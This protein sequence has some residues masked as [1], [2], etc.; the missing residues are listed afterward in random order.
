MNCPKC[1]YQNPEDATF[2]GKC[3]LEFNKATNYEFTARKP[4]L[5]KIKADPISIIYILLGFFVPILGWILWFVWKDS[6]P[7][8][9]RATGIAAL[10]GVVVFII[11]ISIIAMQF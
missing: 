10:V 4:L 2:C 1:Y 6:S 5:D 11:L 9:A 7:R 3:G 8:L